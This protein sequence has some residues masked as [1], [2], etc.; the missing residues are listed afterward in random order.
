[1]S[2]KR[3]V[4]EK[5][6]GQKKGEVGK[7]FGMGKWIVVT[8]NGL[9]CKKGWGWKKGWGRRKSLGCEKRWGWKKGGDRKKQTNRLWIHKQSGDQLIGGE[10]K[11]REVE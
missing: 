7:G 10:Q 8:E 9:E 2:Q 5:G 1:M 4:T 3:V 6:R 11:D